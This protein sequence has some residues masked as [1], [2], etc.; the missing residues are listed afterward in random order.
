MSSLAKLSI[1]G[2]TLT[3]PTASTAKESIPKQLSVLFDILSYKRPHFSDSEVACIEKFIDTIPNIEQDAFGNRILRIGKSATLFSC[4]TDTVH[5]TAGI[6]KLVYDSS[7]EI[8]YKDDKE[9]LGAD[10]AAGIWI[11]LQLIEAK[12]PGL[13]IF[14]RGEEVG[15]QGSRWIANKTPEL[16]AGIERA[17]AF[18]RRGMTDIITHQAGGRCC[19]TKFAEV[20]ADVL[21][22]AHKPSPNG[23][24]TDT[25]NYT[26][27]VSECTNISVGYY[28]EHSADEV[29]DTNYLQELAQAAC[30]VDWESLPTIREAFGNGF[31]DGFEDYDDPNYFLSLCETDPEVAAELL[32]ICKPTADMIN[33]A[34]DNVDL[35]SK[36]W[37]YDYDPGPNDRPHFLPERGD[38]GLREKNFWSKNRKR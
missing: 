31:N 20:L 23:I 6:Q 2:S 15:G 14:H 1:K 12:V 24:F 27:L 30:Q 21:C 25:A 33:K 13:Y 9:P 22:M 37:E 32:K 28:H 10:D 19:S 29:L 35:S 18:D 34:Y 38:A 4:H 3:P 26:H 16:L 7:M 11:L 36:I 8:I 5:R 17:V